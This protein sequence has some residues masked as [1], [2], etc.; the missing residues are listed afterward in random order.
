MYKQNDLQ[1]LQQY[2]QFFYI[3]GHYYII[4]GH[5]LENRKFISILYHRQDKLMLC[6]IQSLKF[7][8]T[9]N[10]NI[11]IAMKVPVDI[12]SNFKGS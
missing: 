1:K 12:W 10:A 6:I 9:L 7:H 2:R 3:D 4:N 11:A 8:C 5:N